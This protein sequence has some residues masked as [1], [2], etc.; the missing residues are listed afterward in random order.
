VAQLGEVKGEVVP[1]TE[2]FRMSPMPDGKRVAADHLW[3]DAPLGD[4]LLA[5][6][7]LRAPSPHSTVDMVAF[8]GHSRMPMPDDAALT[9]G[10]GT[11][12]GIYALWDDPADD[13]ANRDWV[14]RVDDALTPLRSG[15]Y[16]GEA[17]L[18][19][20]PER[21]ADCF[22]PEALQRLD[23]LRRQHDPEGRFFAWP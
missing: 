13:E 22:S 20:G 23:A 1:F 9:V 7:D 11:G 8:G 3:S 5:I 10:G 18:T 6:H 16:V 2:L 4:I 12:A 14:R 21:R 15:R 19:A 17:D